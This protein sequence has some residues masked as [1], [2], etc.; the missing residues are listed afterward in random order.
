MT[1]QVTF[2]GWICRVRQGQYDNGRVALQLIDAE[3][4]SPIAKATVNLPDV[5]LADDEV[6]IKDYSENEGMKASLIE[7]GIIEDTG[8]RAWA[9]RVEVPVCRLVGGR[10][11]R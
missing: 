8:K 6:A 1:N 4:G 9:G 7:A 10:S 3:D 5:P 2:K 11:G